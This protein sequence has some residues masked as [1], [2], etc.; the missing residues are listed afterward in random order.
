MNTFNQDL[1]RDQI[2]AFI[3]TSQTM[4]QKSKQKMNQ[5]FSKI[6]SFMMLCNVVYS[7]L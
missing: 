1:K 7:I 2:G 5:R 6:E 4:R 3:G